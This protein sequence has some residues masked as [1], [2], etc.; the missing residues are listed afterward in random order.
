MKRF[1]LAHLDVY[2][3]KRLKPISWLGALRYTHGQPIKYESWLQQILLDIYT[4]G[5]VLGPYTDKR[6]T[7]QVCIIALVYVYR[8]AHES[9]LGV[10]R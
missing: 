2:T 4:H 7:G 5:Q 1:I 10:L 3:D 9:W 6:Y 8:Q